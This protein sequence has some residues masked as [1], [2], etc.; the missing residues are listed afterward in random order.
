[1]RE[2]LAEGGPVLLHGLDGARQVRSYDFDLFNHKS[3]EWKWPMSEVTSSIN[4]SLQ[5]V[6]AE[7]HS[8]AATTAVAGAYLSG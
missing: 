1:M 6:G 8:N 7:L 4:P 3:A 2:Q 5:Q